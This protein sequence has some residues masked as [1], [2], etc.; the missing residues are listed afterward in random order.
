MTNKFLKINKPCNENWENMKPNSEG[1]F[2]EICS[3]KVLDFTKLNQFELAQKLQKSNGSICGRV[4]KKQLD[5]PLID[6]ERHK[7]Y[8]L[9][10]SNV[11]SGLMIVTTLGVVQPLQSQNLGLQTEIVSKKDTV[12]QVD[13]N[14]EAVKPNLSKPNDFTTLKGIIKDQEEV[15]IENARVT[16]VS[17]QKIIV[18]NTKADGTFSIEVPTEIIDDDNVIRVSYTEIKNEK[19]RYNSFGFETADYILSKDEMNSVYKIKALP[20]IVY[21]GEIGSEISKTD[22][23]PIVVSEGIEIDFEDFLKAQKDKKNSCNLENKDYYHFSS[24]VAVALY[25]QKAKYGLFILVD[26]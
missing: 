16:F 14:N 5:L 10:Y 9:P 18:V 15:P 22:G 6:F 19:T 25:G 26:K 21:L 20:T 13:K 8:K 12:S 17:I 24:K 1:G 4:T 7:N 2:C 23:N 3:K 11:V